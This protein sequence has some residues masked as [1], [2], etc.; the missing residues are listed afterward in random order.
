MS[1]GLFLHDITI[2]R[3]EQKLL[4]IHKDIQQGEILTLQGPSGCGKSTL[5]SY[6]AG[7]LP[8][9]FTATGYIVLKGRS[10]DQVAPYQRKIGVMFQDSLLFPHMS[11]IGNLLFGVPK[12]SK[13]KRYVLAKEALNKAGLSKL[14]DQ[15]PY[16]LSGGQ[17]A[18]VSL[19]RVLLSQP[20]AL[21]LDEP[22]SKLDTA[23]RSE[24]RDFVFNHA[25]EAQLP[26]LMVTHDL[27]DAQAA[28]GPLIQLY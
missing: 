15:D 1:S 25:R 4:H 5:L 12:A 3:H 9:V 6:I 16:T 7:F 17:Q 14:A 20:D 26:V 24:I 23:L 22:F 19:M 10:L 13:E 18:R 27:D 28:G 21:L 11:V 8:N 2:Y